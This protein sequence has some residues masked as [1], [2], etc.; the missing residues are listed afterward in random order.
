[1]HSGRKILDILTR[2]PK[3]EPAKYTE[4]CG[5]GRRARSVAADAERPCGMS[6]K[7]WST[8]A[9]WSATTSATSPKVRRPQSSL[10]LPLPTHALPSAES[11]MK[12]TKSRE[13]MEQTKSVRSLRNWG[14]DPLKY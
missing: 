12:E 11:K 7:T 4:V 10:A 9:K 2:N 13:E 5:Q 3:K 6:R 14:H 8:C 1:M